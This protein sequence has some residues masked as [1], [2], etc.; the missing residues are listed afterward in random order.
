L[1]S[2]SASI[3]PGHCL[4]PKTKGQND[5]G[6]QFLPSGVLKRGEFGSNLSG[7]NSSGLYHSVG[8]KCAASKF[9]VMISPFL[10]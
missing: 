1:S 6:S 10:I 9:I 8:Q 2:K 5:S 4:G 3:L 7:R